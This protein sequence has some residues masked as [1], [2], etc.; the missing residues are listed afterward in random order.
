MDQFP[1]S[2]LIANRGEIAR[3]IISTAR[4]LG[5]RT[6][7]VGHA[8]DRELPFANEADEFVE[9]VGDPP[10]RAYLD[11]EQLIRIAVERDIAAVHP[12]YGF[13]AENAGFAR[14]VQDAGLIWVGPE[15]DTI[16]L[17]GDKIEARSTVAA[18]GVPVGG[19]DNR[20]LRSVADAIEV[21]EDVGYPVMVKAAG[22]GGGIGMAIAHTPEELARAYSGTASM[23]QRSFGSDR[24]FI[25]RFISSARHIEVQVLGQAD[26][27]ITLLGERDCSA[28]RRHQKVVEEAPAPNLDPRIRAG[29]LDAAR[30][31]ASAVGY[32]N[33]GTVE[34]LLDTET[35]RFVFLEMNT[36]I[37]VEHPITELTHDVDIVEQQLSIAATGRTT[38][39]DEP[40]SRGHAIEMRVCAED[41]LRFFPSPGRIDAWTVPQFPGVRIDAGYAEG[42][43]VTPNFDSLVA[44][45]CTVGADRAE[46]IELGRRALR[47]FRIEG[48]VTNIPFLERILDDPAFIAGDYDTGIVTRLSQTTSNRPLQNGRKLA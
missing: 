10:V 36:R 42:N 35:E 6:V 9:I 16:R 38:L 47:E 17:M 27:T 5:I 15:P 31:A 25:E 23:A 40:R 30:T 20:S 13:L 3:R 1:A 4:R 29:L 32:R 39:V 48:L 8:V 21:A 7:A 37:Q 19:G 12:G 44:K 11:Q 45:V 22:G 14:A 33:A 24:V 18:A 28:Q 2:L 26:G 34:F 41:P 46:A 43:S